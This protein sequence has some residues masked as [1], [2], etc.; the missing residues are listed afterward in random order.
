MLDK[1]Q[2]KSR[3]VL[4][5]LA[6]KTTQNL[7]VEIVGIICALSSPLKYISAEPLLEAFSNIDLNGINWLIAGVKS[8]I[9]AD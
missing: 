6:V 7:R 3:L 1:T 4:R 9:L 8:Y 2:E 5:V